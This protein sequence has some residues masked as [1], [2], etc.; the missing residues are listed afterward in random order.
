[1]PI[2]ERRSAGVLS[3]LRER[4]LKT[5]MDVVSR[6]Q[7]ISRTKISN[8]TGISCKRWQ[9]FFWSGKKARTSFL[10]SRESLRYF[11]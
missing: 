1:M 5:V 10:Q 3:E 4:N 11:G 6:Y 7:P 2:S 9:D 8:L